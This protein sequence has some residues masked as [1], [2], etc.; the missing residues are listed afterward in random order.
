MGDFLSQNH[1]T[2]Y[3]K[4]YFI[5]HSRSQKKKLSSSYGY[6]STPLMTDD[7][8]SNNEGQDQQMQDVCDI[9]PPSLPVATNHS[10]ITSMVE[11]E[12]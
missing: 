8:G 10:E 5:A 6:E 11:L 3:S 7:D 1:F 2:Q 4:C 12:T 9:I